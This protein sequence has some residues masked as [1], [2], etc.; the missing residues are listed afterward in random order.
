MTFA[1]Q[2]RDELGRVG[3]TGA[4]HRQLH[5]LILV[6]WPGVKIVTKPPSEVARGTDALIWQIS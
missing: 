2:S 5:L 6:P 3:R 1:H 4:D